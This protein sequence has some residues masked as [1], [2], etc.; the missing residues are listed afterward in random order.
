KPHSGLRRSE[1][2]NDGGVR[3]KGMQAVEDYLVHDLSRQSNVSRCN[4][5]SRGTHQRATPMRRRPGDMRYAV[6]TRPVQEVRSRFLGARQHERRSVEQR[7]QK[8]L[9]AAIAANVIERAPHY[10]VFDLP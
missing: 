9:Q 6:R 2:M 10:G 7:A 4:T 1:G 3:V 5:M 8:D